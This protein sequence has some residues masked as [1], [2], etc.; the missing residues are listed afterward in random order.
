MACR[1]L[2][3]LGYVL[4]VVGAI[5]LILGLLMMWSVAKDPST[6]VL[7]TDKGLALVVTFDMY[8]GAQL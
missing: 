7:L 2:T 6:E 3:V 4:A 5:L 8:G 1:L